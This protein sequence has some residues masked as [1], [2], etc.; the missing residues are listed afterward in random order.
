MSWKH[1]HLEV[2][3]MFLTFS[4]VVAVVCG[5][6]KSGHLSVL[7]AFHLQLLQ[8]IE[9]QL[10]CHSLVRWGGAYIRESTHFVKSVAA[11]TG[12]LPLG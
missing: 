6:Q 1:S 10:L 4:V 5:V 3:M 9:H 12:P 7:P 2:H 11:L 8:P